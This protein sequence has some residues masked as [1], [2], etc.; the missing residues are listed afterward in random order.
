MTRP[1]AMAFDAAGVLY[2]ADAATGIIHRLESGNLAV[3]SKGSEAKPFVR[4]LRGGL[5]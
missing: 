1:V 5:R 2:I 3:F 4:P